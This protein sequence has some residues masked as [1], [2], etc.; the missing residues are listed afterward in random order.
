MIQA[1]GAALRYAYDA[2]GRLIEIGDQS[3][4]GQGNRIRYGLDAAGNRVWE[5][6]LDASGQLKRMLARQYDDLGQ[7]VASIR[8]PY[9]QQTDL[10]AGAVRKTRYA[11]DANGNLERRLDATGGAFVSRFDALNRLFEQIDDQ[12]KNGVNA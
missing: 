4:P 2:A 9:A 8:A 12:G 3:D 1:G 7:L 11:Y 5:Q 10:N 6:T